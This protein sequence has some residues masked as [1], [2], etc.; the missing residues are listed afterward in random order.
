MKTP[1]RTST[2]RMAGHL[3]QVLE[4]ANKQRALPPAALTLL[5]DLLAKLEAA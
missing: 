4:Q 1:A 5:D 2:A 3:N